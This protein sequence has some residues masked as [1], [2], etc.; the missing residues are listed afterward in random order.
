MSTDLTKIDSGTH[1]LAGQC[2]AIVYQ[3]EHYQCLERPAFFEG[4]T[5]LREIKDLQKQFEERRLSVTGPMNEALRVINAWF[6]GPMQKLSFAEQGY[7]NKMAAFERDEQLRIE[8][9]KA[10]AERKARE[11]REE[12]ERRAAKA[13]ERGQVEKAQE[14]L[15]RTQ[16]VA[17]EPPALAPV[18]AA[19]MSFGEKWEFDL[20]DPLRLPREFLQPDLMKIGQVVRALKCKSAAEAQIPGIRVYSRPAVA[21]RGNR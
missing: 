9:E 5:A 14:L 3:S 18:K 11:E 17:A 12:L 6:K 16:E 1:A 7:K 15:Q 21:A 8:R 19:G 20:I 2:D 4:A 10:E 13:A